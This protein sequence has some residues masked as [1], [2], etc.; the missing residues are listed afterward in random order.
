MK[1]LDDIVSSTSAPHF[2]CFIKLYVYTQNKHK[3]THQTECLKFFSNYLCNFFL[4][5][6]F[7]DIFINK[8]TDVH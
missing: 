5:I 4:D 6:L 8:S 2:A 1:L 7:G 3:H